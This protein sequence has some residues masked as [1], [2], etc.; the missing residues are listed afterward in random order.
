MV[1]ASM[2]WENSQRAQG[3]VAPTVVTSVVYLR[4]NFAGYGWLLR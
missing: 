1:A 3:S 4:E 2:S